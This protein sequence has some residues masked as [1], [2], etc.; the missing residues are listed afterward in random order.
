MISLSYALLGR[1]FSSLWDDASL[2]EKRIICSNRLILLS[3]YAHNTTDCA[4]E[5]YHHSNPFE[6]VLPERKFKGLS[7]VGISL[8]DSG[9]PCLRLTISFTLGGPGKGL[10]AM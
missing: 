2:P 1:L 3:V 8:T 9:A 10:P 4:V 7:L 5:Q 6:P